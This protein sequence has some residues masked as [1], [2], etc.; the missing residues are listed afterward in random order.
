LL[1]AVISKRVNSYTSTMNE[2]IK[3]LKTLKRY[4]PQ[5][6]CGALEG[7]ERAKTE[8]IE[9]IRLRTSK[10]LMVYSA[11]KGYCVGAD[12]ALSDERG[13]IVDLKDIAQTFDAITGRSAYAFADEISQGFLTLPTGIR[14]G[15]AGSAVLT[16]VPVKTYKVIGSINFRIPTE[17]V[18][19]AQGLLPHITHGGTLGNT[20]ILSAPKLGKTT[21]V[22]DIARCAG[23]GVGMARSRVT[24]IDERQE[25]AACEFGQPI[26]DVGRETD[27]ISGIVKHTAVFMALRSMSPDVIVTDEIGMSDDLGALREAANSG[28]AMVTTA[29]A[30]DLKS[31]LQRLFFRRI[32]DEKLFDAYVVLSAQ[33]GRITVRQVHDSL[34]QG[35]LDAPILLTCQESL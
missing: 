20:L 17:A 34:G 31:L 15:I 30:P 19:I 10:P 16:N 18:G 32:F 21:L 23:S 35:L 13:M 3:W 26:F 6:I 2:T 28:V 9:E 29:H 5:K 7:I 11:E 22:R 1:C 25:L 12:G 33:L 27:V 4:L 8:K 24:L 14:A